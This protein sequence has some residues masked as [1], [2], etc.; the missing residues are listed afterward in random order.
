MQ[1][2]PVQWGTMHSFDAKHVWHGEPAAP[3]CAVLGEATQVVPFTQ[4]VQQLPDTH[5]PEGQFELFATLL[6]WQAPPEH[7]SDVQALVSS[8]FL[9]TSPPSPHCPVV[10]DVTQVLLLLRHVVQQTPPI[11][12]PDEHEVVTSLAF[13]FVH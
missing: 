5:L 6:Y 2:P 9:Q 3:Q 8:Q 11:H 7:E 13:G 1:T 10:R 4:P 12:T